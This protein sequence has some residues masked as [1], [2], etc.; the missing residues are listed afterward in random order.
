MKSLGN[1]NVLSLNGKSYGGPNP[2]LIVAELSGNHQ[3]SLDTA[4]ALV[5]AAADC[6]VDAIKL[7]TY[8]AD[9]MTLDVEGPGF[10]IE[11]DDSL[12]KGESLHALYDKAHTPWE[13][14]QAVFQRAADRGMLA[15]SSP[16]D[17]S[18]VEFLESLDV[19]CYKIASFEMTDLPLVR[20]VAETGKP[21]IVSTG[22]ASEAE[23]AEMLGVIASVKAQPPVLLKCT[24]TY[25]STAENANLR[26]MPDMHQRFGVPVGLSDHS[27]GIGVAVAATALGACVIEKHFVLSRDSDAVDAAFSMEP[28]EM[29]LLV[30]ECH[31]AYAAL[32][33]VH[34]GGAAAEQASFKFRR[35]IY[36]ARD[37]LEGEILTEDCLKVIRPGYGLP[38]REWDRVLGRRA[39]CNL[40]RGTP[41]DWIHVADNEQ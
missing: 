23:I 39:A 40:Q 14:H 35:S 1:P 6:G 20:R 17:A 24:S 27:L 18:A 34:Y 36:V 33:Q 11:D 28:A 29:R 9:T 10:R 25:P 7:Q 16:F 22:M 13:W 12:W 30:E 37:I 26:T 4:L 2:P 15:F 5:D 38:P 8:T 41:L 19:P 21:M 31:R 3:Q 32:G